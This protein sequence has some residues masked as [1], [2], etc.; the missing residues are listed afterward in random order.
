M[1][2]DTNNVE[3]Y[4][5]WRAVCSDAATFSSVRRRGASSGPA[6]SPMPF[7]PLELFGRDRQ[8]RQRDGERARQGVTWRPFH[9]RFPLATGSRGSRLAPWVLRA[10]S[11]RHCRGQTDRG[12]PE[13]LH[14]QLRGDLTPRQSSMLKRYVAGAEPCHGCRTMLQQRPSCPDGSKQPTGPLLARKKSF[15][16]SYLTGK[17]STIL[18]G[19]GCPSF[20]IPR[21]VLGLQ[22]KGRAAAS[23]VCG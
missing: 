18:Q 4:C 15:A 22:V 19:W 2:A 5:R 6:R 7:G 8:T 17:F 11:Q 23:G 12:S 20:G 14:P 13:F 21:N 10:R 1:L 3:G 16:G 9:Q